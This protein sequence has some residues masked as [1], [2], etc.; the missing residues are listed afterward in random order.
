MHV[1]VFYENMGSSVVYVFGEEY[2][3]EL[4]WKHWH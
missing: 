1:R 2:I 3:C 4:V